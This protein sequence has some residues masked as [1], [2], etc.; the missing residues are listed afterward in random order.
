MLISKLKAYG[1]EIVIA[2]DQNCSKAWG[3]ACRPRLSL[4]PD[5]EDDFAYIP[6][7]D[8]GIAPRDPE[9]YEGDH[10]K[11]MHP[12]RHNKWCLREC[13]RSK[14]CLATEFPRL[15]LEDF[16]KPVYNY[17]ARAESSI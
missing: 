17:K 4:N 15:A 6:D 10:A 16:T 11:P 8:L 13:E 3:R 5:D 14:S 9:T 1:Q 12:D 2:C 7:D